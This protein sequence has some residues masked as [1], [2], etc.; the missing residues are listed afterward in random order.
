MT[1]EGFS[2]SADVTVQQV[3]SRLGFR[4]I[5]GGPPRTSLPTIEVEIQDA[6]GTLVST[7]SGDITRYNLIG[8]VRYRLIRQ[9]DEAVLADG[10][11]ENFAGYSASGSTVDTLSAE[12]DAVRRLMVILADQLVTALYTSVDPAS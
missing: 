9:S 2:A 11:V 7:A 5:T 10:K 8:R 1:S 3:A 12:R 4:K 6:N